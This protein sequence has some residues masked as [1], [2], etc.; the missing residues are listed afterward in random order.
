MQNIISTS[1]TPEQYAAEQYH[2]QVPPPELCPNCDQPHGLEALGYYSRF[3]TRA[4]ATVLR[5]WIRRF[6]CRHCRISV[7]CLPQFAQP[8][9]LVNTPT[10][11]AGFEGQNTRPEVQ[12]WAYLIAAYWRRFQQHLGELV[13]RVGL[14]FGPLPLRTSARDVWGRLLQSWGSL[15]AATPELVHRFR[16]CL[17]GTYRCHQRR[18]SRPA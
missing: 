4:V 6:F 3:I 12:R 8:Y 18:L 15:A 5:I 9:R 7:S 17:F 11:E 14:A 13:Q 1:L 16:T 2:K 10:I